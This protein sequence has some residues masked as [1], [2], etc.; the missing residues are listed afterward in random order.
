VTAR[1]A[2]P[3]VRT[4]SIDAI[5]VP[6]PRLRPLGD[7]EA[8]RESIA[9]AGLLQPL[10]LDASMTLVC[11]LHRLEACRQLGWT[12]IPAIIERIDGPQ[13]ELAEIDEN[14]CRRELTVLE[15]AEHI[16][17][18]KR[19]WSALESARIALLPEPAPAPAGK[20]GR[21][22]RDDD[23]REPP[24]TAFVDDT[25][26]R[27][28]RARR[29]VR[30]ELEIGELPEDVRDTVRTTPIS[31]NKR[32]LLA[33]TRMEEPEALAAAVAVKNG[34]AKSVRKKAPRREPGP[35]LAAL[36]PEGDEPS[37]PVL[38]PLEAEE[39]PGFDAWGPP[40]GGIARE[41]ARHAL[42]D[43]VDAAISALEKA[44]SLWPSEES[45]AEGS[46]HLRDALAS[47][48][49]LRRWIEDAAAD[50]PWAAA[51]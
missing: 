38:A 37:E 9:S 33:L 20:R 6:A 13:A 2:T 28:G 16:A 43:A 36:A 47:A 17:K 48:T 26:R 10:V 7:L 21:A 50:A 1:S 44:E 15:R 40:D 35:A 25:A 8:L 45:A 5:R 49:R 18:R 11:G 4:V 22:R 32:E 42:A 27:T 24:L 31:H 41:R 34:E 12:E 19:L 39:S 51:G 23:P 46:S 29:A 30:E 3:E 14:L